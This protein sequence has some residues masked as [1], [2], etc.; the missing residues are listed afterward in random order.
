MGSIEK[1]F[2]I[3]SLMVLTISVNLSSTRAANNE[4]YGNGDQEITVATGSPGSLGLLRAL[5]EPFCSRNNCRI[6]WGNMG[7]GESLE[8]L[9]SGKVDI[10]MVHAPDA[11]KKAVSEGWGSNR[12][13]IGGNEFYILGPAS[14]PAGIK[15][16]RSVTDAYRRI[17][18]KG[19]LFFTRND[20]SGTH[21][22]EMMIWGK[23]G[24]KPSG[25]WYMAS[26]DF[27]ASTLMR[28]DMEKGYFMTDSSTYLAEKGKLKNLE[29]LFRGDPL[30]I[31]VYHI[32]SVPAEKRS[33]EVYRLINRFINFVKSDEGQKIISEFGIKGYGIPL[34]M[35]ARQAATVAQ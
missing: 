7:S 14:D 4:I 25:S 2:F 6:N 3:L 1:I 17:A 24:I 35:N 22:K 16:L 29:I 12:T 10:I 30:L 15:D 34:Y 19:A 11:E 9:K 8:A 18:E 13:L 27:M 33:V 31:N 23:A 32:M 28:A 20:N 5:S 21:K 26:N